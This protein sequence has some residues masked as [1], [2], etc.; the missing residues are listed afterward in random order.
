MV[1][2]EQ[3]AYLTMAA[4]GLV[5]LLISVFGGGADADFDGDFS[6]DSDLSGVS[7][8]SIPLIATFM[9]TAGF[10]G[11]MLS[12]AGFDSATTSLIAGATGAVSFIAIYAFMAKLLIPS[13]GSSS[14]HE[15][16]F[17]GKTGVVTETI[18]P[19]GMGAV[20]LTVRGSRNVVSAR[21]AG[22]KIP[23]GTEVLIKRVSDAVATVEEI[24]PGQQT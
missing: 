6:L 13:Q 14:V 17:E 23:I 24:R 21:S 2:V 20:A 3:W 9:G 22:A 11:S 19:E 18:S 16:E 5:L 15:K 12:F 7:P 4:L 8:L 10:I 1:E